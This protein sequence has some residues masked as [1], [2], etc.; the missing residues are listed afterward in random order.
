MISVRHVHGENSLIS[1]APRKLNGTDIYVMSFDVKIPGTPGMWNQQL[2]AS[3]NLLD[4]NLLDTSTYR[5]ATGVEHGDAALRYVEGY[6]YTITAR[7]QP[8]R[9]FFFTEIFRSRDLRTWEPGT[10][11]GTIAGDATAALMVPPKYLIHNVV[12]QQDL[13]FCS[14]ALGF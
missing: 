13:T 9:W 11:M 5:M 12:V 8:G 14:N 6:W 7:M 4:W 1:D 10:G 2:A 3:P